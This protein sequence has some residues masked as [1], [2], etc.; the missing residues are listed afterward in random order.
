MQKNGLKWFV[1]KKN[2]SANERFEIVAGFVSLENANYCRECL[3]VRDF[4]SVVI[5]SNCGSF[6]TIVSEQEIK[7]E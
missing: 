1:V 4:G 5:T 6:Y 7:I 3:S 2:S